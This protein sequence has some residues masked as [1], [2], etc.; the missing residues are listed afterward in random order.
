MKSWILGQLRDAGSLK[1]VSDILDR[2]FQ[3]ILGKLDRLEEKRGKNRK[4]R[5]LVLG[6]K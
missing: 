5:I 6:M 2:L 3:G 4:L 1:Y